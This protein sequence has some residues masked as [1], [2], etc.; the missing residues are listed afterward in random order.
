MAL[1]AGTCS[2][3]LEFAAAVDPTVAAVVV[4]G[5]Q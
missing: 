3:A 1:A 2:H 4:Y 5:L